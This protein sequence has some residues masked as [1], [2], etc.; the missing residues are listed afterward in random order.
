LTVAELLSRNGHSVT[1]FD[2]NPAAG[3]VMRYG[4]PTFKLNHTICDE[5]AEL[6][7]ALGVKF[8]FNKKVGVDLTVED[9]L[10][11]GFETVFLGVGAGISAEL[12][13][14]GIDLQGVYSATP[15]LIRANV[16]EAIRP[17]SL[18]ELPDLGERVAVIGGGNTAIDCLRTAVRLGSKE[19]TC[20]YRRTEAEMPGDLKNRTLAIE[21]GVE[22]RWL[23]QP[24]EILGNEEGAVAGL[25]CIEM[26]LGEPDDT[27]RR[28]PVPIEGSEFVLDVNSVVL[29]LGY[30]PD[31]LIGD[32]TPDLKTHDWGL[33]TINEATGATS[34]ENV[35]AGGDDVVGPDLVVTAVAQGRVAAAG[36]HAYMMN[37]NCSETEG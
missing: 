26:E 33:I 6:L 28:R 31:T 37:Q 8:K 7:E 10:A 17:A 22:F 3:G 9:L 30:W 14:P 24:I 20:I 23:T 1:V 32:N 16:K 29:A 15:F 12:K 34:L 11:Q 18:G 35:F 5:K 19:V 36:M 25:R 13:I 2:A 27:G 21:E 4:I